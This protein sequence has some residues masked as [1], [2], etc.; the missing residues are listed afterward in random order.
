MT[1]SNQ[2]RIALIGF[3]EAGRAFAS[4]WGEAVAGRLAA[5]DIKMAWPE[6]PVGM[7][8]AAQALGLAQGALEAAVDYT[9]ERI[10]FGR[11]LISLAVVQDILG[12]RP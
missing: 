4:G 8:K 2:P 7:E 11:P 10:Q 1:H 12:N 6:P 3:G 9:K 5:Y